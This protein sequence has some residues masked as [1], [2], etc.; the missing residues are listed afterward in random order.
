MP[1]RI[2]LNRHHQSNRF[3]CQGLCSEFRSM[4]ASQRLGD[5][6]RRARIKTGMTLAVPIKSDSAI[7]AGLIAASHTV[8]AT[9]RAVIPN[10]CAGGPERL[11]QT[12][13]AAEI[14]P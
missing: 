3:A 14:N 10:R 2:A 6:A 9:A 4:D 5:A 12:I 11:K 7:A 8:S 1:T 13:T